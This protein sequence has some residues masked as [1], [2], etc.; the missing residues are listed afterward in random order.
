MPH[1]WWIA[2]CL[3]LA[4]GCALRVSV[5][6]VSPPFP[7]RDLTG[8]YPLSVRIDKSRPGVGISSVEAVT[9]YGT[10][11]M[12]PGAGP[13]LW[14]ATLPLSPCVNGYDVQFKAVWTFFLAGN[15]QREPAAGVHQAWVEGPLPASCTQSFGRLFV[16]DS[17][18]DLPDA[19]PGDGVCQVSAGTACTLRAAVMEA[20]A[21]RGQ[22]RI[23]LG[24][25]TYVLTLAGGGPED[26][27][28]RGDLDV[29]DEVA[30]TGQ[31]A[32]IQASDGDRIFDVSPS[33]SPVD[34]ELRGLT[35][36]GGKA[37]YGGG[38]LNRGRLHLF[39]TVVRDNLA[40]QRGGGVYTEGGYVEIVD[41]HFADNRT[42][43]EYGGGLSSAGE[44]PLVVVRGSSFVGNEANQHGG[45]IAAATGRLSVRDSTLSGNRSGVYGGGLYVRG[46]VQAELRHVTIVGNHADTDFSLSGSPVG[47]GIFRS[48]LGAPLWM[49]HVLLAGN[50]HGAGQGQPDDCR[51]SELSSRGHNLVGMAED[52]SGLIASDL[53]GTAA[54]PIDP[55]LGDLTTFPQGSQGHVP[56]AGSPALD[57]DAEPP[58]DAHPSRCTRDDQRGIT[59]PSGPLVDGRVRCDI[60]AVERN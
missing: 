53:V 9:S 41:S 28:G 20:N 46:D 10:V 37:A 43:L 12:A 60:G 40:D 11:A 52:C 54:S 15:V 22:D 38:I 27:A 55:E 58:N 23:E 44:D 6:D 21:W 42:G 32:V 2:G 5:E 26:D 35:V 18:A 24:S 8:L 4:S 13:G 33:G 7:A 57:V 1:T 59:R 29:Y 45:A 19:D 34:L 48:G 30:I 17:T 51:G 39:S 31:G 56:K 25:A 47:G 50:L 49:S 3:A 16:V 36:R 14:Q